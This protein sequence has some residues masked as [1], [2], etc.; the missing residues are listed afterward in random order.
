MLILPLCSFLGCRKIN[1]SHL[2][3]CLFEDQPS[4]PTDSPSMSFSK[5]GNMTEQ[6]LSFC[7]VA[8]LLQVCF[9]V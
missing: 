4:E 8:Q 2:I 1:K 9:T 3:G 7:V 5:N 6:T